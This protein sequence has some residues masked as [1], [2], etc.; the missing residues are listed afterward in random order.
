MQTNTKV[1]NAVF[2]TSVVV[3]TKEI[4]DPFPSHQGFSVHQPIERVDFDFLEER[5]GYGE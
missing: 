2:K 4:V 5:R 3:L 1:P